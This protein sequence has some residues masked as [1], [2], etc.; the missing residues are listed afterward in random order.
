M[1]W[2]PDIM[3]NAADWVSGVATTVAVFLAVYQYI[4]E[5]KDRMLRLKEDDVRR[6]TRIKNLKA[7]L[8]CVPAVTAKLNQAINSIQTEGKSLSSVFFE[9]FNAPML[10]LEIAGAKVIPMQTYRLRELTTDAETEFK[11][12]GGWKHGMITEATVLKI[13]A[14][15]TAVVYLQQNL[16]SELEALT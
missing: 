11:S 4:R 15:H 9:N 2:N 13:N 7:A 1:N 16:Q 8:A 12:S 10:Q 5:S 6:E 14:I 3:G